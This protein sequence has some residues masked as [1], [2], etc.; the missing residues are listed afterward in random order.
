MPLRSFFPIPAVITIA[1]SS[2]CL[3][4]L[5][6]L[7]VGYQRLYVS[8]QAVIICINE[9]SEKA[10]SRIM[11]SNVTEWRSQEINKH[12]FS[13]EGEHPCW[14]LNWVGKWTLLWTESLV[15]FLRGRFMKL[16]K[17][18]FWNWIFP[19]FFRLEIKS[20]AWKKK[21]GMTSLS[22]VWI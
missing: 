6:S 8:P 14:P 12:S 4:S 19:L 17:R 16:S 1:T 22:F 18:L 5:P 2:I 9:I 11:T 21:S 20:R 7:W 13:F 10:E 15:S 3:P